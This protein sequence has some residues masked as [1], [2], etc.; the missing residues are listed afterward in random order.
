M[1]KPKQCDLWNTCYRYLREPHS[2][3]QS[4]FVEEPYDKKNKTCEYYYE[5]KPTTKN[6]TSDELL[7]QD[8][9]QLRES[10]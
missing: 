10:K 1:C 3:M 2:M 7:L 8:G 6:T 5:T 9:S 4:Y